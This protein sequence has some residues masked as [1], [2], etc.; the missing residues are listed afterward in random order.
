MMEQ[1]IKPITL[2]MGSCNT[3]LNCQRA[4]TGGWVFPQFSDGKPDV[5]TVHESCLGC[6][7][8]A[9]VRDLIFTRW[10]P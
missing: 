5:E 10:T 4:S 2:S 9:K 7:A 3:Q 8:P 1:S 6:C